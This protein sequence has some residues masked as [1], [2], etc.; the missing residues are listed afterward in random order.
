VRFQ[1]AEATAKARATKPAAKAAPAKPAVA[2]KVVSPSAAPK[3]KTKADPL[4]L[5]KKSG[6]R[7]AAENFVASL[8]D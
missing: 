5:L 7:D 8:F 2:P 6:N 4:D 1:Q 3:T